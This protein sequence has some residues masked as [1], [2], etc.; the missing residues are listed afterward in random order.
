[1]RREKV[2]GGGSARE[3][4]CAGGKTCWARRKKSAEKE[5][6]LIR[7]GDLKINRLWR[8]KGR[9]RRE[10]GGSESAEKRENVGEKEAIGSS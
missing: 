5:V 9:R 2:R 7:G 6:R 8:V 3:R 10:P 1:M 4:K